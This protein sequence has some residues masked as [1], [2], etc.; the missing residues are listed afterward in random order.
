MVLTNPIW[1]IQTSTQNDIAF[2]LLQLRTE[3]LVSSGNSVPVV[4]VATRMLALLFCLPAFSSSCNATC[5]LQAYVLKYDTSIILIL[6]FCKLF[7]VQA[8]KS[9]QKTILPDCS[10]SH[11]V[12]FKCVV[13][14]MVGIA[15]QAPSN[16]PHVETTVI[17][18]LLKVKSKT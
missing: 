16:L 10:R 15:L 5:S 12:A 13:P 17:R 18:P 14:E 9:L 4:H 2:F 11:N 6:S 3:A 7:Y 8:A 1:F